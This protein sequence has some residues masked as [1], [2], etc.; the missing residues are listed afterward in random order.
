M[1]KAIEIIAQPRQ[2]ERSDLDAQL[3]LILGKLTDAQDDCEDGYC[4]QLTG[5]LFALGMTWE[6]AL[7]TA[8]E[9]WNASRQPLKAEDA[10]PQCPVCRSWN[11]D[12]D[13]D[14]EPPGAYYRCRACGERWVEHSESDND[15]ILAEL[16]ASLG[17]RAVVQPIG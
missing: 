17:G 5:L 8:L 2:R 11:I 3:W 4:G 6:V 15:Y 14:H 13:E 16:V 10:D 1:S 12:E 9:L 7:K